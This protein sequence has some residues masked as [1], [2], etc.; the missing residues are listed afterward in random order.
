MVAVSGIGSTIILHYTAGGMVPGAPLEEKGG[1]VEK[2]GW[3][4]AVVRWKMRV[5]VPRLKQKFWRRGCSPSSWLESV[6]RELGTRRVGGGGL[7]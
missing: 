7:R 6:V 1:G 4:G 3:G 2:T 5:G